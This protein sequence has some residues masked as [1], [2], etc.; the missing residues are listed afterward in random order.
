MTVCLA[1]ARRGG[2]GPA[3]AFGFLSP[4]MLAVA[5]LLVLV[6]G[7][8]RAQETGTVQ[9]VVTIAATGEPAA[10]ARVVVPRFGLFTTAD[11]TGRYVLE[12]V[13]AGTHEILAQRGSL[14]SGRIQVEVLA[15]STVTLELQVVESFMLEQITVTASAS[16]VGTDRELF[17]SVTTLT[18]EG[19]AENASP[20]LAAALEGQPGVAMRGFGPGAARP[21]VRGFDGDRVLIMQDGVRTG[22]LSSQSGDHGTTIDPTSLRRLEV[23]KGPATLLYGSNAIGGVVNAITNHDY[24]RTPPPTGVRGGVL[25]DGGTGNGQLGGNAWVQG[26]RKGWLFWGNGGYRET[27]DY[28]TPIGEVPNSS[29]ELGNGS[30]GMGYFGSRAFFTLGA[31][32][33]TGDYGVPFAADFEGGHEEE[34]EGEEPHEEEEHEGENIRIEMQRT[35]FRG[36]FGLVNLDGFLDAVRA[37]VNYSGWHHEEVHGGEPETLFDN[38][39]IVYRL[40]F[41]QASD[42][43]WGGNFGIWGQYRDYE[44]EGAEALSPPVIQNSFA[45]FVVEEFDL[46]AARVQLGLRFETARYDVE[47]TEDPDRTFAGVSSSLGINAPVGEHTN[48]YG[49][50]TESYRMPA[51]EELYNNGPHVGTLTYEV[52]N[53]NLNRELA[54]GIDGGIKHDS[55]FLRAELSGY[56]YDITDYVFARLTGEVEDGL[57]VGEF[58]QADARYRGFEARVDWRMVDDL[59]LNLRT[60]Y[61]RANLE[62]DDTPLPRIPPFRIRGALDWHW[63]GFRVKP[64]V[65]WAAEQDRTYLNETSTDGYVLLNVL[66]SYVFQTGDQQHQVTLSLHNLTDELYRNHSSFIKDLAPEMGR[67]VRLTYSAQIF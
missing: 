28:D 13:P 30:L 62:E 5:L 46:E 29:T 1:S 11:E 12:R 45:A 20:T 50:L 35:N 41:D 40:D 16:G 52:G 21:I 55:D 51:L 19:L 17:N 4:W 3:G 60:D 25:L 24:Y 39:T 32:A 63:K 27:R 43:W 6:P 33:E 22:D 9:G 18:A 49:N 31:T 36:T 53:S 56:W 64:E 58:D 65:V 23:V 67:A 15:H 26:G 47:S 48:I 2:R 54:L 57:Q 8:I 38:Q 34:D 10:G 37:S 44:T 59:W 61:V 14:Q 7:R 42:R 66:G